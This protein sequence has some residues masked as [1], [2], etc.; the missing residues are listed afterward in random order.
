MYRLY[1]PKVSQQ[2]LIYILSCQT[3]VCQITI[4]VS[5][6][7]E[8]AIIKH[9]QFIGDDKGNNMIGQALLEHQQSTNSAITILE[10]M[11]TF[12]VK[13]VMVTPSSLFRHV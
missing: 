5:P 9:L 7:F 4:N 2:L 13:Q 1:H 6:L 8:A 10:W 3:S 12:K 11:N